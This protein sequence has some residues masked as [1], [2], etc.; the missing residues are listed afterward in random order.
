MGYE[1]RSTSV[2]EQTLN[3]WKR[4]FEVKTVPNS[5][6]CGILVCFIYV[7][8]LTFDS[9]S[10]KYH[11]ISRCGLQIKAKLFNSLRTDADYLLLVTLRKLSYN[12]LN[13]CRWMRH[14]NIQV[15]NFILW[16]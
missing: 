13:Q 6:V 1:I 16:D 3:M 12:H 10:L 9:C 15:F 4:H 8:I 11:G 5:K 7:N 2:H 14:T